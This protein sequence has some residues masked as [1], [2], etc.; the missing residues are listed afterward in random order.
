MVKR[1]LTTGELPIAREAARIQ[2]PRVS[3]ERGRQI[4]EAT[5]NSIRCQIEAD[6]PQLAE[7][8]INGW[9]E[10]KRVFTRPSPT[11]GQA[12]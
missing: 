10:F 9:E 3:R 12:R 4:M 8:G 1:I 7:G 6:Y 5:V 2:R 11:A